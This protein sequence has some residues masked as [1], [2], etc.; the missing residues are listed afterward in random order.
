MAVIIV[1]TIVGSY[2]LVCV[3]LKTK[4]TRNYE[5]ENAVRNQTETAS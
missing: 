4:C 2:D 1:Y 3:L 5:N